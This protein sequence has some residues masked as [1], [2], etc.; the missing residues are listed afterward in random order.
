MAKQIDNNFSFTP[1]QMTDGEEYMNEAQLQHFTK[2]LTDWKEQLLAEAES[3]KSYI[4]DESTAM[5]DINDRATQEEEFA[6]ALRTRD[7]ERKLI[8]KIEKSLAEIESG[9]Y[10]F[11]ETCGVEIGLRRLEARPTATQCIDCKTLSEIKEKQA[12]G[13]A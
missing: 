10:G 8:R 9:D 6:L 5:P 7:R 12:W 3:T 1:Y 4:Q 11:C 13:H 2:I